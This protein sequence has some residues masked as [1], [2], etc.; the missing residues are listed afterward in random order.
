[1]LLVT[2]LNIGQNGRLGNQLFQAASAIGAAE[3]LSGSFGF[4]DTWEAAAKIFNKNLPTLP[5]EV[6]SR[7]STGTLVPPP[8]NLVENKTG[9]INI[10]NFLRNQLAPPSP[11]GQ[12][13]QLINLNGYFQSEKYFNHCRDSLLRQLAPKPQL[14]EYIRKKYRFLA[15][16]RWTS[17]HV[18]RGDY[19]T[20]AQDHPLNPHPCQSPEYYSRAIEE[21][22]A[23]NLLVFSDDI[24]WCKKNFKQFNCLFVEEREHLPAELSSSHP[25]FQKLSNFNLESDYTEIN[26]MA[27]CSDHIIANSSF[28]WWGAWL[29]QSSSKKVVAPLNWFSSQFAA[30]STDNPSTYLEDILP[31]DW[32]IL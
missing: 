25:Q 15:D 29:N 12:E 9:Y 21:L 22:G 20:L 26:I 24:K 30:V 8:L 19:T 1:M 3:S 7:L 16:E 23:T 4:P 2:N 31:P 32:I 27:Q 14:A 28:S 18:R 6:S 5:A 10:P 17:L 11:A 13:W